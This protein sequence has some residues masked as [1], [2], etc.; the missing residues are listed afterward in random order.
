M[1]TLTQGVMLASHVYSSIRLVPILWL[2]F[3]DAAT[4]NSGPLG[5]WSVHSL[6]M[7]YVLIW[8][9][10]GPLVAVLS[11]FATLGQR[12]WLR[13]AARSYAL[14]CV[15]TLFLAPLAACLILAVGHTQSRGKYSVQVAP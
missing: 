7:P 15:P 5:S 12:R 6:W 10:V 8:G 4:M 13:G 1:L 9:C 14:L 11:L 3:R 2:A